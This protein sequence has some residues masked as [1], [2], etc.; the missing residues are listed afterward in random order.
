MTR[1]DI[2]PELSKSQAR[3]LRHD[4][5]RSLEVSK[6]ILFWNP[7]WK[8]FVAAML[9]GALVYAL[10][11]KLFAVGGQPW[12]TY[13]ITIVILVLFLGLTVLAV[14]ANTRLARLTIDAERGVFWR[15]ADGLVGMFPT[16]RGS[17]SL[18]QLSPRPIAEL[19]GRLGE[20]R[21]HRVKEAGSG[22]YETFW[23]TWSATVYISLE[24]TLKPVFYIP[25]L[26]SQSV[27]EAT[28]SYLNHA[29]A[30][31]AQKMSE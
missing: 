15:D 30:Q 29:M 2:P 13:T 17:L 6:R 10:A 16:R 31:I 12:F 21:I 3:I 4:P 7:L 5:G 1:V 27:A 28:Q 9:V 22:R 25:K 14:M 20:V 11:D 26:R 18:D 23:D 19:A 8:S 24:N